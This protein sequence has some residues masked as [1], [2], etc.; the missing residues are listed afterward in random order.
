MKKI[1][2][3]LTVVFVLTAAFSGCAGNA[4]Q[5]TDEDSAAVPQTQA[6]TPTLPSESAEQTSLEDNYDFPSQSL[7]DPDKIRY[8]DVPGMPTQDF[9]LSFEDVRNEK[10][11]DVAVM[12]P[13]KLTSNALFDIYNFVQTEQKKPVR[14]FDEDVQ[15]A[16]EE[17]L[18]NGASPDI[19]HMTEFMQI[20]PEKTE[21]KN[22]DAK[23][24]VVIDADY[25]PNRL[26]IV[27]IGDRRACKDDQNFDA[28]EWTPLK[29][30]VTEAGKIEF[31]IPAEL[32]ENVEGEDII[33]SV[34]T[35]RIGTHGG[36]IRYENGEIIITYPSKTADDTV[37]IQDPIGENGREL[38]EDF[39]VLRVE[40]TKVIREEV[41][42][43]RLRRAE[44]KPFISLYPLTA[45]REAQLLLP[46]GFDMDSLVAYEIL[47]VDCENYKHTYGDVLVRFS[48]AT[49]FE[50]G[51]SIVA[52]LGLERENRTDSDGF[53]LDW[54]AMRTEV[55]D[56]YVDI[57]FPQA[58]LEVMEKHPA[59]LV[60]MSEPLN[61]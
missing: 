61:Q 53:E 56:G 40:E 58:G 37:S 13:D 28:I 31:V 52:M 7:S 4:P 47:S 14:Y 27:M 44:E 48:F 36:V 8:T 25:L 49:P 45:Q 57:T 43:M 11:Y 20:L 32:M 12:E 50:D 23:A 15:K 5:G 34:L 33:F 10:T 55:K 59:L 30:S 1:I 19:L 35:D 16:V 22:C 41:A 46:D 54:V 17:L 60:V 18:P 6:S 38:P 9:V 26:V 2:A 24:T 3:L 21:N 29:A 42:E 51:Q 39:K